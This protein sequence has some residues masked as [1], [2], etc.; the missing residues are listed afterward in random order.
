MYES[1]VN[2][3]PDCRRRP[4]NSIAMEV[5]GRIK[6]EINEDWRTS[7]PIFKPRPV[8]SWIIVH[9][10]QQL[11]SILAKKFDIDLLAWGISV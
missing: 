5:L 2:K 6:T 7:V 8:T 4:F 9:I 3:P 1:I 10:Q 11:G